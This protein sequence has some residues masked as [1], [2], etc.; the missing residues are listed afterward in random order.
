MDNHLDAAFHLEKENKNYFFQQKVY[1]RL[2]NN[3]VDLGYPTKIQNGWKDLPQYWNTGIDA[4][5]RCE[6]TRM[7][8]FFK[9]R[10][11]FTIQNGNPVATFPKKLPGEFKNLPRYFHS[12]IDAAVCLSSNQRM[13]LFKGN[14]YVRIKNNKVE[15]GYPKKLPGEF[16]LLPKEFCSDI[17]AALH[18]NGDIFFYKNGQY[19]KSIKNEVFT[20]FQK[21]TGR[22]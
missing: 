7:T 9:G 20:R 15:Q 14:Q 6:P 10:E 12:N 1:L 8:T 19:A 4:A 16:K 21:K 5:L 18:H 11:Y 17:D 22:E 2:S 13:Y 3:K